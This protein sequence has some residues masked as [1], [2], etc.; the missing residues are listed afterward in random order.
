MMLFQAENPVIQV[1]EA[2]LLDGLITRADFDKAIKNP[3]IL[4]I[5]LDAD[6]TCN[7]APAPSSSSIS[8]VRPTVSRY[9]T[10]RSL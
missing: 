8:A 2:L 6:T 1:L 4:R 7:D 5:G 9:L 10:R 3:K